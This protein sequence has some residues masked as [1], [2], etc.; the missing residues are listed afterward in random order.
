MKLVMVLV[1][2]GTTA[3]PMEVEV[4]TRMVEVEVVQRTRRQLRVVEYRV[5]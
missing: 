3:V 4:G 2:V 5:E 1:A